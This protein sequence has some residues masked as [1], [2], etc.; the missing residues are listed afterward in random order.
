MSRGTKYLLILLTGI[1]LVFLVYQIPMVNS[2]VGWR[3]DKF[4][5]YVRNLF[6]PPEPLPTPRPST[7]VPATVTPQFVTPTEVAPTS[8]PTVTLTVEALPIQAKLESPPHEFQ[9]PNNCGPATLSMML[10]MYGWEGSQADIAGVIKP[11]KAD[12]NVNPD[13]L[14]WYVRNY[15]GGFNMEYRVGGNITLLKR[16]LARNYP[17]IIESTTSLDPNDSFPGID[18]DLWSAHYLLLTGY[19]DAT[20]TFTAQDPYRGPDKPVPYEKLEADWKSFNY[21]YMFIYLPFEE[22][23]IKSILGDDWVL[24]Q[25]YQRTL[26]STEEATRLNPDDAFAWFNLGSNLIY[27]ERYEEAARA[28]DKALTIGLP[29]RMLRYQFG[30]YHAYFHTEKY[31]DLL[32][33]SQNTLDL[34]FSSNNFWSEEAWLWK[35]WALYRK[36]DAKGAIAAWNKALE[37]QPDYC[38]AQYALNL[39]QGTAAPAFC[40]P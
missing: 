9:T 12:R 32:L 37:V 3:Y 7:P 11:Q 40:V 2:A 16:L 14:I 6:N 8:S 35:G 20:Q 22:E 17:V 28:Y 30:P 5:I 18:D 38:D 15:A 13:E 31:D 25:N 19:D 29:L 39:V 33:I 27:F 34:A 1:L 36:D 21:V 4:T 10:H 23:E 26:G 24:D